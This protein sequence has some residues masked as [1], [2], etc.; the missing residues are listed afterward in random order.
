MLLGSS[1]GSD[2]W[3]LRHFRFD[4]LGLRSFHK[5]HVRNAG[6]V[7]TA[8][9]IPVH[10]LLSSDALYRSS[11]AESKAIELRRRL[12]YLLPQSAGARLVRLFHRYVFEMLPIVSRTAMGLASQDDLPRPDILTETPTHLLAAL[13]GSA[14][15]FAHQDDHLVALLTCDHINLDEVWAI[16]Y[17]SMQEEICK[18]H[19]HVLQAAILYLHRNHESPRQSA[20]TDTASIWPFMGTVVGLSHNLGLQLECRMMGLPAQEKRLRRRLWWAAFIQDKFLSLH[21][22]RPPYIR[23]DEWDVGELDDFDFLPWNQTNASKASPFRD[24]ARLSLIAETLQADLYSLKSCQKLAENLPDS[25]Q[26]ARPIFDALHQWRASVPIPESFHESRVLI[27]ENQ[28]S[29][30]ACISLSKLSLVAYTWRAL[31][32]PTVRSAPPPQIIDVDAEPQTFPDTGFLFEDL[33]W[34]FSD[35][36]ELELQLEDGAPDS[37]ATVKELY[38]AAQTWAET[39]VKFTVCLTSSDLSQFW[40]SWSKFSLVVASNFL[41]LLLVQAPSAESGVRARELLERW[42][43]VI[44]DH[45]K[46]SPLFLLTATE[47]GQV[48]E[49][50]ITETFCLPSHVQGIL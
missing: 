35:F 18:P 30:P 38:Q 25:I 13:Y 27:N 46:M 32:R 17:A 1:S 41:M 23:K 40:Y 28:N 37:S 6:G 2:P 16:C 8:D 50:G 34:N 24:L 12:D 5:L 14:I 10:F 21:T 4:E 47:L 31:L 9:K 44:K 26:A 49:A 36:P 3:L 29:Y 42:R 45:A 43:Q 7:P 11:I 33:S 15:P 39:L 48:Y 20:F 19:L 22:G